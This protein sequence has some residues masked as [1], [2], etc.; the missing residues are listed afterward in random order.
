MQQ[1]IDVLK[2]GGFKLDLTHLPKRMPGLETAHGF[3]SMAVA[4]IAD[5]MDLV[6]E[7]KISARTQTLVVLR[8]DPK[9]A[10]VFSEPFSQEVKARLSA[11]YGDDILEFVNESLKGL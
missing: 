5:E 3:M 1:M 7:L 11:Q 8:S 2:G 10:T 9:K 4:Q 6:K